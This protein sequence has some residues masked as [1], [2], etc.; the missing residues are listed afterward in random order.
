VMPTSN[1]SLQIS[2]GELGDDDDEPVTC[3]VCDASNG[4]RTV[5]SASVSY[6]TRAVALSAIYTRRES[7]FAEALTSGGLEVT[8]RARRNTFMGRVESVDRPAGFLG[9]TDVERT[10]HM[11]VGYIF[12]FINTPSFRTGAGFN[13][14]YH[15]QTRDLEEIYGHKPQAIYAFVRVRTN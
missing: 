4:Q 15:T 6:G 7:D 12:D 2:R 5:T 8:F 13:F 11:A 10:T 3:I 1:V 9:H 14:D